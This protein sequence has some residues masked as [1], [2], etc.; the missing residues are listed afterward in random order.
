[1]QFP[2]DPGSAHSIRPRRSH[3][4][5]DS[6]TRSSDPVADPRPLTG[7]IAFEEGDFH[8]LSP[9]CARDAQFNDR[10]LLT[11]RKLLALGK[12]FLARAGEGLE[13]R[14]SLHNPHAF[15]HNQVRRLWA[16]LCRDKREKSRLKRVI[17]S[18]LARDLDAAYRNAYLC[19]ALEADAVE[20]SLRIHA[21]A[22]FDGQNLVKRVAR[23]GVRSWREHLRPLEGFRLRLD[24]WK[25]EWRCGEVE[26][27]RGEHA[28]VVE[29]RWP[30]PADRPE[31]RRA[32][33]SPEVP[34][35]LLVELERLLPLYRYS[36]WSAESDFLFA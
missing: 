32:L 3:A 1:M 35:A 23:E 6:M 10:R 11:R 29:R 31:L 8:A 14:T 18:E 26:P 4:P 13:C 25:G 7:E 19:L 27:E 28:L 16:Y 36:A 12:R 2:C 30:A 21:D 20:V 5:A 17:G 34:E 33:C 22:W 24:D 9:A 15:N